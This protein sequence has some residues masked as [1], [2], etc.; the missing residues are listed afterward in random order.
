MEAI[1]LDLGFLVPSIEGYT[2]FLIAMD[3]TSRFVMA[4]PF[5]KKDE[6]SEILFKIFQLKEHQNSSCQI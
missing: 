2:G 5:F 1:V 6:V 3:I 4:K